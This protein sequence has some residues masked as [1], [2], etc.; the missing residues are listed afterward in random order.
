MFKRFFAA[1]S[2]PLEIV[3]TSPNGIDQSFRETIRAGEISVS[4]NQEK[5]E[6]AEKSALDQTKTLIGFVQNGC[7]YL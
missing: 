2:T 6:T 3:S 1:I 7:E 5:K 4:K